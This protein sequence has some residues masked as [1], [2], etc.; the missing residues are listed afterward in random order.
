MV[1]DDILFWIS[2]YEERN[3]AMQTRESRLHKNIKY[4]PIL[5]VN[6]FSGGHFNF[7]ALID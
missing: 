2:R 4:N 7:I 5:Y 3:D 1:K 6:P